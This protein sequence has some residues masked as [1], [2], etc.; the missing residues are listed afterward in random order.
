[1]LDAMAKVVGA[2]GGALLLPSVASAQLSELPARLSAR[3]FIRTLSDVE[4]R[5]TFKAFSGTLSLAV[6][7]RGVKPFVGFRTVVRREA[8]FDPASSTWSLSF[9]EGN[10][11]VDLA[12][13]Q[14]ATKVAHPSTGEDVYPSA[15]R[16]GPSVSTV[17]DVQFAIPEGPSSRPV[18]G[19]WEQLGDRAW[20]TRTQDID[21]ENPMSPKE[22]PRASAGTRFQARTMKTYSVS[23]AHMLD[24]ARPSLDADFGL[25]VT[26][27]WLPW[28]LMD[29]RPGRLLWQASGSK[30]LGHDHV[31]N[32]WR[33]A[34]DRHFPGLFEEAIGWDEPTTFLNSYM[35]DNQPMRSIV[36]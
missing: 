22:W 30:R 12:T 15:Y 10:I 33:E 13:G 6:P 9:A 8:R 16:E 32:D 5:T 26:S 27:G 23:R 17:S 4:G 24:H 25:V 2:G 14:E 1:M 7:G 3:D 31:P 20:F 28:M 21:V 36:E 29:Q 19:A 11:F 35:N 34:M 18:Y